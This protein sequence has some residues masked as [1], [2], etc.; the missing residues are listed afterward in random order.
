M[1]SAPSAP[2]EA[3]S[4]IQIRLE[5]NL[6]AYAQRYPFAAGPDESTNRAL[7]TATSRG[8]CERPGVQP[9]TP[10]FISEGD[11]HL[12]QGEEEALKRSFRRLKMSAADQVHALDDFAWEVN[13][14]PRDRRNVLAIGCGSG[15]ELLFLR[16]VLPDAKLTGIDYVD[17][18][19]PEVKAATSVDLRVGDMGAILGALAPEYDMVFS[20]HTLEH[21]YDPEGTLRAVFRLLQPGGTLL[22]TLPFVGQQDSPFA[23][24]VRAFLK[25]RKTNPDAAIP[26]VDM[27][28]LDLGHPWKTNPADA[29]ATLASLG[30][31]DIQVFQRRDHLSRPRAHNQAQLVSQRRRALLA[32]R[33]L[34][35]PIH[36]L[37]RMGFRRGVPLPLRRL[38]F[39]FER[40]VPFGTNNI[41]SLYNEEGLLLATKPGANLSTP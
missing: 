2:S 21:L 9:V 41:M 5:P 11:D 4:G 31:E 28:Y 38:V 27:V 8:V 3:T 22:S 36:A 14:V 23:H 33:L 35:A 19:Q 24:R 20:N 10:H 17:S 34:V 40:R 30:F 15:I 25:S 13:K 37:F 18:I 16:A 7:I 26:A 32:H 39:A 12:G 29:T 6:Q 1:A